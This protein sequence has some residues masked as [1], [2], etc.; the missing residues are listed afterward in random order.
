MSTRA[1]INPALPGLCNYME[2]IVSL[3]YRDPGKLARDPGIL[4]CSDI[5]AEKIVLLRRDGT[6]LNI[7][8]QQ[9]KKTLCTPSSQQI[10]P[11][12]RGGTVFSYN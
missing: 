4:A 8:R 5:P 12:C 3:Y 9:I 10:V 1:H 2:E 6:F 11:S 7:I